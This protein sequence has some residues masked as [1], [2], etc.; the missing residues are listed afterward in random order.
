[1]AKIL[2][3][4][5]LS[6]CVFTLLPIYFFG[7]GFAFFPNILLHIARFFFSFTCSRFSLTTRAFFPR[8]AGTL[9]DADLEVYLSCRLGVLWQVKGDGRPHARAPL[10]TVGAADKKS[11]TSK[12]S[13]G[14]LGRRCGI[15]S[16]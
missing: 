4:H 5:I 12:V 9:P 7:V 16:L 2:L 13:C 1:M 3:L 10:S 15:A 6:A 11:R 8:L 14:K